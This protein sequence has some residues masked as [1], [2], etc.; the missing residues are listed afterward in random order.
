[1]FNLCLFVCCLSA[2]LLQKLR[3]DFCEFF[4]VLECGQRNSWFDFGGDS[5]RDPFLDPD[6]DPSPGIF[7]KDS[8]FTIAF[9]IDSLE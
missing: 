2:K 1:M 9:S 8:L 4:G 5:D 3:M 7:S 6:Y